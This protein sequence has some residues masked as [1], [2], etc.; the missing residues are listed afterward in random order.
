[1]VSLTIVP[2]PDDVVVGVD[3]HADVHVAVAL[4]GVG[5]WWG[6]IAVATTP[7]GFDELLPWASSFGRVRCFGVEGTGSYG[8]SFTRY[9]QGL[10]EVVVEDGPRLRSVRLLEHRSLVGAPTV[11]LLRPVTRLSHPGSPVR[12][13]RHR[14]VGSRSLRTRAHRRSPH[15][16]HPRLRLRERGRPKSVESPGFATGPRP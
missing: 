15:G 3:T 16:R 6:S 5:A 14:H 13:K 2:E 8:A 7:A 10:G 1:M 4:S 9:L 12:C 11:H